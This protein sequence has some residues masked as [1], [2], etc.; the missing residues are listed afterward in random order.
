MYRKHI[1]KFTGFNNSLLK[2]PVNNLSQNKFQA[3]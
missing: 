3:K 1:N 2:T